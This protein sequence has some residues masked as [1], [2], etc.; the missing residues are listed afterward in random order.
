MGSGGKW[1]QLPS[2]G[3]HQVWVH[4]KTPNQLKAKRWLIMFYNHYVMYRKEMPAS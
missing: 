2:L 1:R 3:L 4:S